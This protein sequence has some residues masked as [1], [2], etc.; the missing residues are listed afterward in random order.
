[1]LFIEICTYILELYSSQ[2]FKK[3]IFEILLELAHVSNLIDNPLIIHL[4]FFPPDP[5]QDPVINIRL[6]LYQLF[7]M[8]KSI[9]KLPTD[10]DLLQELELTVRKLIVQERDSDASQSIRDAV[11]AMDRI[12]VSMETVSGQEGGEGLI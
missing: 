12:E 10:R 11:L 2:F 5:L 3:N 4:H 7:P 6:R 1:M 8:L 9:L